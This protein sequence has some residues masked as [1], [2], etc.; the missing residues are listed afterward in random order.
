MYRSLLG[1]I[2]L[3]VLPVT[4]ALADPPATAGTGWQPYIT[5]QSESNA[6][7]YADQIQAQ[8]TATYIEYTHTSNSI[9]YYTV[10]YVPNFGN[11]CS[12]G[13]YD[14]ESQSCPVDPES[15]LGA[16]DPSGSVW[17]SQ[18]ESCSCPEGTTDYLDPSDASYSCVADLEECTS[19]SEGFQGYFNNTAVCSYNS[20]CAEG[21]S[22]GY[23]NGNW[24]C[25]ADSCDGGTYIN[26]ACISPEELTPNKNGEVT[27]K[28]T[29]GDGIPDS[30]DG[31]IDGDGI[32]NGS[33]DDIDGDGVLN[34]DDLSNEKESS[35]SGGNS[36]DAAPSC[37]GDAIDCAILQQQWLTRCA[38]DDGKFTDNGCEVDPQC[39]GDPLLCAGLIYSQK[40]R[41]ALEKA[42]EDA[43]G[44]FQNNGYKTAEDYAAEGGIFGDGVETDV[45]DIANGVFSSRS[46]VSGSCPAPIAFSVPN[47]GTFEYSLE[48]F[49]LLSDEIYWL[50]LLSAYLTAAFIIFRA[51]TSPV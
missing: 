1:L 45:G 6:N 15:C 3:L 36:C 16:G 8:G 13:L 50:V 46:T 30:S 14:Q 5:N 37:S 23:V 4:S 22:G 49:C 25:V 42:A 47:F 38:E 35:A 40:D 20:G 10:W 31:D 19:S 27:S 12:E 44:W 9:D 51:V 2:A 39:E 21:E 17:D 43:E 48:P 29:D 7:Y 32:P 34:V 28:D 26:G 33:D 24:Q 41:C 18:S 11:P